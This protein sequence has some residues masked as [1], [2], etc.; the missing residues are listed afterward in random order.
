MQVN[1]APYIEETS[2]SVVNI[3]TKDHTTGVMSWIQ[4][5]HSQR[6]YWA[7]LH[8]LKLTSL[9]MFKKVFGKQKTTKVYSRRNWVWTFTDDEGN[10]ILYCLVSVEGPSWEYNRNSKPEVVFSLLKEANE[11]L[12]LRK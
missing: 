6:E 2:E 5:A 3:K 4:F 9:Q 7:K 10:G 12:C 11:F 8:E 1:V